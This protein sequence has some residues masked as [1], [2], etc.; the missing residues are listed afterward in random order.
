MKAW[1]GA[2]IAAAV[3]I[4][5]LILDPEL[6]LGNSAGVK[7]GFTISMLGIV[8]LAFHIS[9]QTRE[10]NIS[11][12]IASWSS[13]LAVLAIL[14][15]NMNLLTSNGQLEQVEKVAATAAGPVATKAN[16]RQQNASSDIYVPDTAKINRV[17]T[18][19]AREQTGFGFLASSDDRTFVKNQFSKQN[20]RLDQDWKVSKAEKQKFEKFLQSQGLEYN[21]ET[22]FNAPGVPAKPAS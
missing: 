9:R 7:V 18:V 5:A 4:V 3:T 6:L 19:V 15:S 21:P 16:F 2:A 14:A 1:I 17:E 12:H 13:A 22:A 8:G 10:T 11:R 20:S